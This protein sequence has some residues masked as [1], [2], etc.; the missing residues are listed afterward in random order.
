MNL[1]CKYEV[2]T[3][4]RGWGKE[5]LTYRTLTHLN[6]NIFFAGDNRTLSY[7]DQMLIDLN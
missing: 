7:S 2:L 4:L 6:G 5:A 1:D 3:F